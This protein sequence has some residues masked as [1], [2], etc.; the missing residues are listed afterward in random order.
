M[1]S[2]KVQSWLTVRTHDQQ[3]STTVQGQ[4]VTRQGH[5]ITQ[6]IAIKTQL[7]SI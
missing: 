1:S 2:Q 7:V 6:R 5:S 3:V 4:K